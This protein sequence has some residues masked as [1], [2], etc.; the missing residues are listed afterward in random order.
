LLRDRVPSW[1][2]P[3]AIVRLPKIPLAATGKIDK[4]K[5]RAE[6]G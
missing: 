5:L 6:F 4:R 1:W 3:D 2:L